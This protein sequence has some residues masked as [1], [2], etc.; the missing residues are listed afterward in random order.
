MGNQ[1]NL[2]TLAKR[3]R[4]LLGN[5]VQGLVKSGIGEGPG[6]DNV[7]SGDLTTVGLGGD[8]ILLYDSGG[9][10][11]SEYAATSAGLIAGLDAMTAGDVLE[12]PDIL[13]SGG[14]WT[15]ANGSLK[16]H[17][18]F[19]SILDGELTVSGGCVAERL[20]VIRSEDTASEIYGIV[21]LEEA[22]A[23]GCYLVITNADG[24]VIAVFSPAGEEGDCYAND[25][26]V[27]AVSASGDGYAYGTDGCEMWAEGGY[28]EASTA[29]VRV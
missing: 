21:L 14:P 10:P 18:R 22:R 8:T 2:T 25:N 20:S 12:L 24:N 29:P 28:V 5:F 7:V 17:S 15:I 16:G 3:L 27:F 26:I 23:E 19:G 4:P 6:I 1:S 11:V 13:I 9:N